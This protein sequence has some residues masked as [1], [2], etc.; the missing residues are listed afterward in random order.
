M[1]APLIV[2]GILASIFAPPM[3]TAR[4]ASV[5]YPWCDRNPNV[6][7]YAY[8]IE[9]FVRS[10]NGSPPKN[11]I[12]GKRFE[13]KTLKVPSWFGPFREYDVHVHVPGQPRG[14]ERIVLGHAKQAAWY[15]SD[16]Y[17]TLIE[18]HPLGCVPILF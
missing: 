17:E 2:L 7:D 11:Y 1:L 4:P 8:S 15:T 5:A 3:A 9:E 12:G 13:N 18:M 6:P 10:H 16:H 14:L